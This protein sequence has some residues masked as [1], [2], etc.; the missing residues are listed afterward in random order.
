MHTYSKEY[1][2]LVTAIRRLVAT[3][4]FLEKNG[5]NIKVQGGRKGKFNFAADLRKLIDKAADSVEYLA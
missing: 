3:H 2:R 1:E 5:L 4:R